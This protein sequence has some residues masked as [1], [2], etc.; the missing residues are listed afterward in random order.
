MTV[1]LGYLIAA[2]VAI[3]A[4]LLV[5]G[6]GFVVR[7]D[8]DFDVHEPSARLVGVLGGLCERA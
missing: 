5:T 4:A 6:R 3:V 1:V 8:P 7:P 2:S